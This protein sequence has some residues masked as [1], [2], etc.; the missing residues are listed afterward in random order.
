MA[1]FNRRN[2]IKLLSSAPLGMSVGVS[3]TGCGQSSDV[4]KLNLYTW[5]TYTGENTIDDFEAFTNSR[6]NMSYF[7][8]ND[9]LFAKMRM[10]N[11]GFDLIVPSNDL[12][13][14]LVE[15]ELLEA[16]DHSKIPNLVNIAPEFMN[17]SYDPERKYSIPYTWL[18]TGIGYRISKMDGVPDSWE[19]V[20][21]SDK[22]KGKI[23]L[24]GEASELFQLGMKY[25]GKPLNNT[26]PAD[27]ERLTE[28]YIKQKPN[29]AMFHD[30]NGQDALLAGDID[31]V[32]EYNGDI[33]QIM[34][35]DSD[36]GFVVPKEGS[37]LASDCFS[38]PKGAPNP[39]LAHKFIDFVLDGKNG[40]HIAE[41]ILYPTPNVAAMNLM[42]PS[43][44][45][46][47]TIF[48]PAAV[49]SKCEYAKDPGIDVNQT[50]DEAFTRIRS[51]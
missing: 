42:P 33:A 48:P 18:V 37:L 20:F 8:N 19:W 28:M 31:I 40:A 25:L 22:Y 9:E 26:A 17:V 3:L 50:F 10:G 29:I 2:F 23:G 49:L 45:E 35:E 36:I 51:S 24:V 34:E 41:S 27:I 46:N 21:D 6:V 1:R 7:A 12:V 4:E 30:D 43:Y 5:D 44:S 39:E 15:A 11:P 13:E 38:I 14:R 32:V 47:E 16:I